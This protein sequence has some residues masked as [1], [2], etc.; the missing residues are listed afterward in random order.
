[1]ITAS[2]STLSPNNLKILG[3]KVT[4][5]LSICIRSFVNPHQVEIVLIHDTVGIFDWM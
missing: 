4:K 5:Y 2:K 3:P 1:M